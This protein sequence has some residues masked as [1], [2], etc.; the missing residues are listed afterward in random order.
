MSIFGQF[1]FQF[2]W[3]LRHSPKNLLPNHLGWFKSLILFFLHFLMF[4]LMFYKK[5]IF[6]QNGRIFAQKMSILNFFQFRLNRRLLRS[7]NKMP[8]H[9]WHTE[10]SSYQNSSPY[11]FFEP[12]P[13]PRM[14]FGS[15]EKNI[16]NKGQHAQEQSC[17]LRGITESAIK[18]WKWLLVLYIDHIMWPRKVWPRGQTNLLCFVLW[19][20]CLL[21]LISLIS[22]ISLFILKK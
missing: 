9:F 12:P 6:P 7:R 20:V 18:S 16:V 3:R 22:L 1:Q 10:I 19:F 2:H 13:P 14:F 15:S 5:G 4:F 11:R 8:I 17:P 21:S